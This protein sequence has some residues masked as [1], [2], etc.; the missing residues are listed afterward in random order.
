VVVDFDDI[1]IFNRTQEEHIFHLIRVLKSLCKEKLFINLKKCA[2][3]VSTVHFLGFI[4]S[5]DGVAIDP[6]KVKAIRD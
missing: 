2:F 6:N 4:V 1:L 3:L 5:R